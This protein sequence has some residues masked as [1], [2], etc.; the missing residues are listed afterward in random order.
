MWS[1]NAELKL[2]VSGLLSGLTALRRGHRE[3]AECRER[4]VVAVLLLALDVANVQ[5]FLVV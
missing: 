3:T 2:P 1:D 5:L 4:S